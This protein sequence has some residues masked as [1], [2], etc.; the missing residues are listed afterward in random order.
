MI[1]NS[2]INPIKVPQNCTAD[3]VPAQGGNK[4]ECDQL[5][6]IQEHGLIS[7]GSELIILILIINFYVIFFVQILTAT[8]LAL[9]EL[10]IM[11][12]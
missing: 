11:E 2:P 3:S 12:L 5:I 7:N 8:M 4:P 9:K 6:P 1:L 10:T